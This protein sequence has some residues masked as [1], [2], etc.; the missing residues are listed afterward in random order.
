MKK[1]V[2]IAWINR[3]DPW[4]HIVTS[5]VALSIAEQILTEEWV[6]WKTTAG[7]EYMARSGEIRSLTV[8]KYS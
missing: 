2:S 5:E 4:N 8:A 1:K 6:I 3:S 7:N